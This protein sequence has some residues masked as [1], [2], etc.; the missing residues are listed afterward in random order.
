MKGWV[1]F[2]AALLLL[3]WISGCGA[4]LD[5]SGVVTAINVIPGPT[6]A[7]VGSDV[8]FEVDAIYSDGHIAPLDHDVT[9]THDSLPWVNWSGSTAQCVAPSPEAFGV[10]QTAQITASATINGNTLSDHSS[11]ECKP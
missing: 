5:P 11:V 6:T 10:A 4:V 9:W 1:S 2:A 7:H 8:T 3:A